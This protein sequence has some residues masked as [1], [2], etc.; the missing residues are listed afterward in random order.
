[1]RAH[2]LFFWLA[3]FFLAGVFFASILPWAGT[4]LAAALVAAVFSYFGRQQLAV[5]S[6]MAIIGSGYYFLFESLENR[7]SLEPTGVIVTARG[8]LNY[9]ELILDNDLKII[10]GRHPAYNYGDEIIAE[11]EIKKSRSKFFRGVMSYPK[12]E[13]ID[14]NLGHP[15]KAWLIKLRLAFE[16]NLKKVL[17]QEKSALLSGLTVG[18]TAEISKD[19]REKM[20]ASGTT[21]ITALSGQNL[22]I[23]T[24]TLGAVFNFWVVLILIIAFVIMTGA[25]ASL[26]RAAI[27]GAVGLLAKRLERPHSF[28]NTITA[29]A[30]L[31]V[32]INPKILTFDLGFQLS[33][34]ATIGL[35]YIKSPSQNPHFNKYIWP[36]IAAQ[37]AV[38]PLLLIKFSRFNPLSYLA[39]ILIAPLVPPTM[40]LGLAAGAAGFIFQPLALLLAWFTNILLS[41]EMAV[42]RIFAGG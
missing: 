14:T 2:D 28:R 34:L 16:D 25:E 37:T 20:T 30:L 1:M 23:I 33:F 31:M 29:A 22:A 11:G 15:W 12:I 41:Y 24:G 18:A 21:H 39:N 27:M 3:A 13:V 7:R 32:L 10:T 42:I 40:G 5:L 26:V 17:P 9:Q 19:F 36:T 6:L 35:Q 4:V 8:H 38:L